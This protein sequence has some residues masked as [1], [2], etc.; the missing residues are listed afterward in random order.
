[1]NIYWV[2]KPR[3]KQDPSTQGLVLRATANTKEKAAKLK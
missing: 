3:K 2:P 1:M